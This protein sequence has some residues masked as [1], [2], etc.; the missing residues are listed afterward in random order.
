MHSQALG[1]ACPS[2]RSERL[3]FAMRRLPLAQ[4]F[5]K[6]VPQAVDILSDILLNSKLAPDAIERERAVILVSDHAVPHGCACRRA[7]R[8][9]G[10][11]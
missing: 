10:G 2:C 8:A 3:L 11:L 6:D 1:V 5:Q 4:V 9:V 7:A